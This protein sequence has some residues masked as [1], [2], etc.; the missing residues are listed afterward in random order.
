MAIQDDQWDNMRKG[1][2]DRHTTRELFVPVENQMMTMALQLEVETAIRDASSRSRSKLTL[3]SLCT[4]FDA[5]VKKCGKLG[6]SALEIETIIPKKTGASGPKQ[7][8]LK[9]FLALMSSSI[10]IFI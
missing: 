6:K 9:S 2:L 5:T 3:H 1:G 8:S 4:G 7:S 10:L